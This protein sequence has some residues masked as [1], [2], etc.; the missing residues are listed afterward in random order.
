MRPLTIVTL[1]A[2]STLALAAC[3]NAGQTTS[4]AST[5]AGGGAVAATTNAPAA[6]GKASL[7]PAVAALVPADVKTKGQLSFAMDASY[8]PFEYFDT[9][10]TTIIGFDADL[11]QAIGTTMGIKVVDVNA[12]FDSIL[13][14]LTSQKY[15]V[16]MS[17]F[18]ASEERAKV[19]DFVTYGAGGSGIA[20]P[21]G[22]PK[23]LSM[24]PMSLCGHTVAAQKGTIQGLDYLPKF[25]AQCTAGGKAAITTDLYPAQTDANLAVTSGRA[26]AVMA[27]SVS[28]TL[29]AKQTGTLELAAGPDYNPT[30]VAIAVPNDSPLAPSIGAALKALDKNGT[31]AAILAKWGLPTQFATQAKIGDIIK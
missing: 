8:A 24:D 27:D 13:I 29:Q 30:N 1:L 5:S 31:L 23:A 10:N 12:A 4:T 6:S 18:S 17:A 26:D 20:V 2:T 22:N 15:D 25:S 19:V 3:T 21:K 9:D 16:G 11:S 28:L 14:G 7:D